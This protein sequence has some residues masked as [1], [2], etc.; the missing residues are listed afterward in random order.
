MI[1]REKDKIE[2]E[3]VLEL[4][5]MSLAGPNPPSETS[6]DRRHRSKQVLRLPQQLQHCRKMSILKSG[7]SVLLS[8][9]EDIAQELRPFWGVMT[10]TKATMVQREQYLEDMPK[11]WREVAK[12]LWQEPNLTMVLQALAALDPSS[13]PG[14]DGFTGA[15][16][17]GAYKEF[18][19]PAML[20]IIHEVAQTGVLPAVWCTGMMRCIPKEQGCLEVS[21][22][23]PI[24]ALACNIKWL[25]GVL[26]LALTDPVAYVVPRK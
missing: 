7:T 23:R 17:K 3:E 2:G 26:K 21:K 14:C 6:H 18:F 19:A 8:E 5:R 13:A 10:T 4:P 1:D 16:Y 20:D 25:T 24:P 15:F 9:E 11:R 22:Q 12:T